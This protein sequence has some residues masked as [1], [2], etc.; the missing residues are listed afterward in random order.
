MQMFI[1]KLRRILQSFFHNRNIIFMKP[2]STENLKKFFN[3]IRP[4][5]TN[6]EL[7]RLGGDND[8]GYLVPDCLK[9][10]EL[11]IS[12][13]VGEIAKFE[14]EI[15][16]KHGISSILLDHTIKKPNFKKFKHEFISKKLS[17]DQ[18]KSSVTLDELVKENLKKE[19]DLILQMDIEGYEYEILLNAQEKSLRSFRIMIIEFHDLYYLRQQYSYKFIYLIFQKLLRHFEIVHIH[20]N[21]AAETF[22]HH[23]Y[24]FPS[25]IEITLLRK[26][27]SKNL[28]FT[29][30][31]NKLDQKNIEKLDEINL[32]KEILEWV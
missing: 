28:G 4:I 16:E 11:C 14:E 19:N 10:I 5:K 13:G 2:T 1:R 23:Q 3:L 32:P 27:F 12:P 15:F 24:I 29:K 25:A 26:D 7:I 8:G 30:L 22:N 17:Y 31:P 21:N 20:P 9:N 18:G 6:H